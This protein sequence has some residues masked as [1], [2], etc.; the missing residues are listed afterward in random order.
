MNIYLDYDTISCAVERI[1]KGED[2]SSEPKEVL[3]LAVYAISLCSKE[4]RAWIWERLAEYGL[5]VQEFPPVAPVEPSPSVLAAVAKDIEE[6]FRKHGLKPE[7]VSQ[8]VGAVEKTDRGGG[9]DHDN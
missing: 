3:Q 9:N 2:P 8:L 7:A 6:V 4:Q 5:R 1:L